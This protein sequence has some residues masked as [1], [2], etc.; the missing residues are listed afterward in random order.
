M[1][2]RTYI[3]IFEFTNPNVSITGFVVLAFPCNQF[4]MQSPGSSEDQKK[5]ACERFKAEYPIFRKVI[6]VFSSNK[7]KTLK[8]QITTKRLIF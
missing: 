7:R 5:V 8:E 2:E 3:C 6:N 4:L 1:I